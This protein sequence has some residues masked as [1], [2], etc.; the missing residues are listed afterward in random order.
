VCRRVNG[1]AMHPDGVAA[2]ARIAESGLSQAALEDDSFCL[3]LPPDLRS[4]DL[5]ARLTPAQLTALQRRADLSTKSPCEIEREVQAV[6]AN[7]DKLRDLCADCQTREEAGRVKA[8]ILRALEDLPDG[9]AQ[10]RLFDA[11]EELL[12]GFRTAAGTE[13][14]E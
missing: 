11:V 13:E 1:D 5:L 8:A 4:L 3:L 2:Y 6:Q 7:G 9:P 14:K 10:D 12:A